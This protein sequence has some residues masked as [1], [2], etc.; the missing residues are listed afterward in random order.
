ME[1]NWSVSCGLLIIDLQENL[2]LG[3]FDV[4]YSVKGHV[5]ERIKSGFSN[6]MLV[7]NKKKNT[8]QREDS[9]SMYHS[10]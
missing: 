3:L 4:L 1:Y 8:K 9:Y 7:L 5:G 2:R 10:I 6:A